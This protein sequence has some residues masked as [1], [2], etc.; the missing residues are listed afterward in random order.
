M[1]INTASTPA[2]VGSSRDAP[3]SA[4][5]RPPRRAAWAGVVSLGLGIFT[6]VASEFLPASLLSPIAAD[7]GISEGTAGQLVT[8]TSVIGI[9]GGPLVVSALP[10]IDRRWVMV[11]LTALAVLSNVLVSIAPV[12]GLMLASRL[13]LG[14]A[15]SGFWAM[16]LAVTAQLVPADRLGR[17][18][19]IVNMGV[20]LA[21]IAAVPAGAFLG[22]LVGWRTVF[23]GAA[24]A[25]IVA[26]VVQLLT[27]PSV[28][29]TGAPGFRTLVR[30]AARPVVAL[31]VLAIVLIAGGHFIGFTYLRPAF[32]EIGG[33][34]PAALA[35]L[36]AVFGV[37]SF[38]GNLVAG[39]IA[40]RRLGVL[41]IGAP[42]AIGA[43]T[44]LYALAG[45]NPVAAAIAVVVWGAGFGAIPTMVQTWMARVA[46][47]RLESSG[48][49]VVAAFQIA[50]TVGA[51][52]GGLLVDSVGVQAAFLGGGVAAVLGAVVLTAA[53]A[54]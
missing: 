50:I 54:R 31:G 53:K 14:L 39:P 18:M 7:L 44:V 11:A 33:A 30:T 19:T 2:V 36:L 5:H 20:S 48:G 42:T 27:L 46:P 26:L 9:I 16:S 37:A 45:A 51:A 10:R 22:E 23:L 43:A 1:S 40:D 49:L 41:V 25:G 4:P 24:A 52:V 38:A 17:A 34:S 47:D 3:A 13:L 8:A 6:L 28:P 35:M 12:F 29:P 32:E 21:T 15:I